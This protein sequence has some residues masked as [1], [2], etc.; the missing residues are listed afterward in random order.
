MF[1]K[2]RGLKNKEMLVDKVME[3]LAKDYL[4]TSWEHD[5]FRWYW[6]RKHGYRI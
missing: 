2:H 5:L 1:Q 6:E 3:I 4:M